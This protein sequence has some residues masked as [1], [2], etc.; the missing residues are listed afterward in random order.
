MRHRYTVQARRTAPTDATWTAA[1]TTTASAKAWKKVRTTCGITATLIAKEYGLNRSMQLFAIVVCSTAPMA[2]LQG[3]STQNDLVVSLFT[4]LFLYFSILFVRSGDRSELVFAGLS[5]GLALLSKGTALLFC[6]PIG[7][8]VFGPK[9]LIG[10]FQWKGFRNISQI[11]LIAV[12]ALCLNAGHYSRNWQLFGTP[13]TSGDDKVANENITTRLVASNLLRN[14]ALHLG[15]INDSITMYIQNSVSDLLGSELNNPDSTFLTLKFFIPQEMHE[16]TAG[17][18]FHLIFLTV[19][20]FVAFGCAKKERR[21]V[22]ITALAIIGGFF[23]F[24]LVLR[25]QPWA[26]RLHLPLFMVGSPLIAWAIA[27]T[28]TR[29]AVLAGTIAFVACIPALFFGRPNAFLGDRWA[30]DKYFSANPALR[31]AHVA[32]ADFF[33]KTNV[34]EIGLNLSVDYERYNWG[35]WEYP[36]WILTRNGS[37]ERPLIKHVGVTNISSRLNDKGPPPEWVISTTNENLIDGILYV[38]VTNNPPLRI[39][40]RE[41]NTDEK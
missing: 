25:W 37:G 13:I 11:A 40:R 20:C 19:A 35:D 39:L 22:L 18:L 4:M 38:E 30:T 1:P 12:L 10:S 31:S 8:L 5:L 26:S 23:L 15:S 29:G 27:K 24:C 28:G 34:K 14:Y 17:N 36:I 32:S 33:N 41:L 9:M 16:D 6:F 2:I 3:S 21:T 7:A